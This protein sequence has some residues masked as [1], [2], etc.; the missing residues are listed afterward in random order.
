M[1]FSIFTLFVALSLSLVSAYYSV[2]GLMAIFSA[3][4]IPIAIMGVTLEVAK[5]TTT[6]WL[7]Y[8]WEE[9]PK[10]IK[11]YLFSAVGFLMLLTSLGSFGFLSKAHLDQAVPS[12]DVQSQVALFDEK[13]KTQRDNIDSY[14]KALAQMDTAVDQIM[15]RTNDEN[16]ATKAANLRK[17]QAKERTRLANDIDLAQK[18]ITKLQEERA[19]IASNLRKVEAEVG[20]IKYIAAV[21]Y[22]DNADQN[23]LEAAVRWVIV[24]IIF[25]FDPLA[26]VLILAATTSLDWARKARHDRKTE[27]HHD[28]DIE[29]VKQAYADETHL[30]ASSV[31]LLEDELERTR[32][33]MD[34]QSEEWKNKELNLQ[35]I[36]KAL[37]EITSHVE[38]LNE[39]I[40]TLQEAY[41]VVSTHNSVTLKD[42]RLMIEEYDGLVDR[43]EELRTEYQELVNLLSELATKEQVDTKAGPEVNYDLLPEPA[44]ALQVE[45]PATLGDPFPV[46]P[47]VSLPEPISPTNHSFTFGASMPANPAIGDM[48]L[49]TI[50]QPFTLHKFNGIHWMGV[51][52][53]TNTSYMSDPAYVQFL[54]DLVDRGD[55][56]VDDLTDLER[57]EIA[58]KLEEEAN[59]NK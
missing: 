41:N 26:V 16:G 9:A 29:A 22:G 21:I 42:L 15:S 51:D 2:L 31:S 38:E 48:F 47:T 43:N 1:I 27:K 13:I 19:P 59:A 50:T 49:L 53:N 32:K 11:F 28:V 34:S 24:V 17:N 5:I 8:Y 20:P 40:A 18:Q 30:L 55:I 52:K 25:V 36:S 39:T 35:H 44:P 4:A 58:A 23:L 46:K 56:D 54:I 7:H 6:V 37:S 3:A 33:S 57:E 12:G 14:R 45:T 10:K